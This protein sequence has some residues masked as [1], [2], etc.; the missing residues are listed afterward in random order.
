[1]KKSIACLVIILILC[2]IIVS[3][4]LLPL[5]NKNVKK[6]SMFSCSQ[7]QKKCYLNEFQECDGTKFATI[8][9]CTPQ[10]YCSV[11]KGCVNRNLGIVKKSR[12]DSFYEFRL[13]QCKEN[14]FV[15]RGRFVKVCKNRI[16]QQEF[17]KMDEVCLPDKMC[18][19]KTS[20]T[21]LQ[22]RDAHIPRT[23]KV[24]LLHYG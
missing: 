3:A 11:D 9:V 18:V 8:K 22:Q 12:L 16:W 13:T 15:C 5:S 6:Q 4:T 21:R 7:G 17:C 23:P 1:M 19:P 20:L 2:S 14:E 10:E 24:P